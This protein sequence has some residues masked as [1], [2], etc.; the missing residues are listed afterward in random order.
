M[1]G[2]AFV[3]QNKMTTIYPNPPSS[4]HPDGNPA[5]LANVQRLI[6]AACRGNR[7]CGGPADAER[8]LTTAVYEIERHLDGQT[9]P[10]PG[11]AGMVEQI[12]R[13][14]LGHFTKGSTRDRSGD[15]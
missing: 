5:G 9:E 13:S 11:R 2:E 8:L 14:L 15:N 12:L 1:A 6:D 4:Q 10:A 7:A 3:E